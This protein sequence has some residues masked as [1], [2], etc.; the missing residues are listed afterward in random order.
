[1]TSKGKALGVCALATVA[2][3]ANAAINAS[4][5]TGGHFVS[6]QSHTQI[7]ASTGI[8]PQHNAELSI[9]IFPVTCG[10]AEYLATASASTV[11]EVA[12]TP[13]YK[14]CKTGELELI[15]H[16]NGCGYLVKIGKKPAKKTQCS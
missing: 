8:P 3:C 11:T 4:A 14:N 15:P 5:T 16:L 10:V 12:V 7:Q 1:M 13:V 9:G 6:E 2:L